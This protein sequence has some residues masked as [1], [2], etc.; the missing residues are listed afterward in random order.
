M[1]IS[2]IRMRPKASIEPGLL[3]ALVER[4]AKAFQAMPYFWCTDTIETPEEFHQQT[5]ELH[6]NEYLESSRQLQ[7]CCEFPEYDDETGSCIDLPDLEFSFRVG[8]VKSNS[9]FPPIARMRALQ[10][11]LPDDLPDQVRIW[12]K[13]CEDVTSGLHTDYLRRLWAYETTMSL[14][15]FG[16]ELKRVAGLSLEE[17]AK[18]A[19]R[20]ELKAVR[21][22]ILAGSV[23]EVLPAPVFIPDAEATVQ[24]IAGDDDLFDSIWRDV[25]DL[26]QLTRTWDSKV[27]GRWKLR[28]YEDYYETFE[29][30]RDP[31]KSDWSR[32]FFGWADRCGH[33]GMGLFL[34]Y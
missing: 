23:S 19:T 8:A 5:R 24:T 32:E 28:Y 1:G 9:T 30:F 26:V 27:K 2:W 17:T 4:Q 10:T 12:K 7:E 22:E 13:W 15:H 21:D 34:D 3:I 11:F 29:Q 16:T 31:A 25:R 33:Q 20:P 18:W 14:N 6:E